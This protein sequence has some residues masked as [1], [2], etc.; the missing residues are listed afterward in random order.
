[1][2][3]FEL[4]YKTRVSS[5]LIGHTHQCMYLLF[6]TAGDTGDMG[7]YRDAFQIDLLLVVTLVMFNAPRLFLGMHLHGA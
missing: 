6:F 7:A 5:G 3:Q 4:Q 1:M 2:K